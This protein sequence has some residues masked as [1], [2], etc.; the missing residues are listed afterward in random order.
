MTLVYFNSSKFDRHEWQAALP[1]DWQWVA[2]PQKA[3]LALL[4][5]PHQW[6]FSGCS[7]WEHGFLLGAG[8]DGHR[9]RLKM[10][11]GCKVFRLV[12][13]GMG[14][15]M[16]H[17][18][19]YG[20]LHFQRNFDRY[21]I[22]QQQNLWQPETHQ[23]PQDYRIGILGGGALAKT[24]ANHLQHLGAQVV[25]WSHSKKPTWLKGETCFIGKGS[26]KAFAEH[27]DGTVCLL[28]AT[29]ST[30]ELLNTEFFYG[31]RPGAFLVNL[32]RGSLVNEADL[33]AAIKRGQ[34]RGAILDVTQIEPLPENH[35]FWQHPN[36]WLTPHVAA[37][38]QMQP[39][40]EQIVQLLNGN[41]DSSQYRATLSP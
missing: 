34:L 29:A 18:A 13:A 14:E 23:P 28:P 11:S 27:L 36:I 8:V 7:N 26:L 35:A 31:L 5:H 20:F 41:L 40:A 17:Y 37:T 39:A 15:Q 32:S 19:G 30:F 4:W 6:D 21:Q 10:P 24:V 9:G 33:M 22:H 1:S 3:N 12:D 2:D 25:I 16:A 38:T